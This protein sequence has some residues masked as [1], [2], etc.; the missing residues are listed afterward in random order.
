MSKNAKFD[1]GAAKK[2]LVEFEDTWCR[3]KGAFPSEPSGDP[4]AVASMLREK[5]REKK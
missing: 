4:V 5:Y 1:R 3:K 2:T